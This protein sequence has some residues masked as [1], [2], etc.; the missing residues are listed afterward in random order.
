MARV[1]LDRLECEKTEDS[2]GADEAYLNFN[3]ERVFGPVSI[4][5]GQTVNVGVTKAFARK[6]R[7]ELFDAD[8]PDEDDSLGSIEIRELS[9]GLRSEKFTGDFTGDG[10]RYTLFYEVFR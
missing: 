4:N 5:D 6:A 2:T 8:S 9:R 1:R 10:A 3:N 7:V